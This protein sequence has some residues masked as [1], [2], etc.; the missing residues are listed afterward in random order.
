[1]QT[2]KIF[3]S[4]AL[5]IL[6]TLLPRSPLHHVQ[7]W[8]ILR[9]VEFGETW[10][11]SG[12]GTRQLTQLVG[13]SAASRPGFSL[14]ATLLG[15]TALL[16]ETGY[17]VLLKTQFTDNACIKQWPLCHLPAASKL[18]SSGT[19]MFSGTVEQVTQPWASCTLD[20]CRK[21]KIRL[22]LGSEHPISV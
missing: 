20:P 17:K 22:V 6:L 19:F 12:D 11:P 10:A 13:W 18:P 1:M 7:V 15:W 9:L 4:D 3:F 14:W 16:S 8:S 2:F 5:R 21:T